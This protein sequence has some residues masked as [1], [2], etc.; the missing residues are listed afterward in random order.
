M[1]FTT[2]VNVAATLECSW[3]IVSASAETHLVLGKSVALR[4][5]AA[6]ACFCCGLTAAVKCKPWVGMFQADMQPDGVV[7]KKRDR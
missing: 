7:F 3:N 2:I 1:L 4:H 6:K 5:R